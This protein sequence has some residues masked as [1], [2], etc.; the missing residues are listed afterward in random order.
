VQHDGLVS[1]SERPTFNRYLMDMYRSRELALSIAR[2]DLRSR[3]GT[4]ALGW[5]WNLL[6]PV[7]MLGVYWL[8]FGVLLA[9][10]RPEN[11]L[12]F[13]AVGIFLFRFVEATV[14][15]GADSVRKNLGMVRQ[16]RF[17]RGML[18][19]AEALR[20]LFAL[21]WQMPVIALIVVTTTGRVQPGWVV[22]LLILVPLLA[23]FGLGGALV[24]ARIAHTVSDATKLL[25]YT[26]RI[27][28]YASGI[29]FPIDALLADHPVGILLP[30]NPIFAFVSLGRHLTISPI[31]DA[32]VLWVSATLWT[33]LVLAVGL[34]FFLSAE[35]RYGRG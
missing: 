29:L 5:T 18:P 21:A 3:H 4:F 26:F 27:L 19:A 15:G 23:V 9:G 14:V 30:L 24:F 6:D 1:L 34:K 2:N 28:F 35:N 17:P 33:L 31:E 7:L 12:A 16:I 32:A 10:R 8:M 20:N 25:P 11:F 13:L 22:L